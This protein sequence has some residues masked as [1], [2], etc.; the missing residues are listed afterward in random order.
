MKIYSVLWLSVGVGCA[1]VL[2]QG[3]LPVRPGYLGVALMLA[4]AIAVRSHWRKADA[5]SGPGSPER[6]LWHCLATTA[7]IAGHLVTSLW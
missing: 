5:D 1:L 6:E 2:L 4:S 3:H 7:L